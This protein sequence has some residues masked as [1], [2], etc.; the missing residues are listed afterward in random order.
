MENE[1][2]K[3]GEDGAIDN[4][5][6]QQEE[7]KYYTPTI[8]EF[9]VGFECEST[10]TGFSKDFSWQKVIIDDIE[11]FGSIYKEDA[12][13]SEFRVKYL[14]KEDI[15]SLGFESLG[16][17]WYNLI[18]VPGKLGYFLYVRMRVFHKQVTIKTYRA[19]PKKY[20]NEDINEEQYLFDGTIKNKSELKKLMQQLNIC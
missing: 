1:V 16:S 11:Y 5:L 9:Y 20:Q 4:R 10:Y 19:D 13:E 6:I 2:W 7:N 3:I 18:R 15:E 17:G 14:D 8:D 12:I